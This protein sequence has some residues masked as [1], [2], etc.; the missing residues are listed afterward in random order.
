MALSA[1]GYVLSD[2]T[3]LYKR[4][5]RRIALVRRQYSSNAH[6]VIVGIGLVTCVYVNPEID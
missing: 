5:R 3:V 1:R 4:H 6:G 2:D